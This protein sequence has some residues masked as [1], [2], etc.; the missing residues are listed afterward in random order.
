MK[1][2]GF[3]EH[4]YLDGV[5]VPTIGYGN[6]RVLGRR[7]TMQD[8]P[9]SQEVAQELLRADIYT[10]LI[11]AQY[12]FPRLREM[13]PVRGE[14]LVNLAFNLGRPK[15]QKF[16]L[17]RKAAALL[18]YDAMAREMRKS[19]WFHQVGNRA[20]RMVRQMRTGTV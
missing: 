1:D 16:V 11:D 17:L 20:V 7:V 10:A 4:P 18:D 2:E 15:L 6:I 5:G 14:V 13:G 8:E 19:H 9:I 12:T 3:S